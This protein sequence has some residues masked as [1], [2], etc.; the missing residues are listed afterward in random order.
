MQKTQPATA[1][2]ANPG[3]L[4]AKKTASNSGNSELIDDEYHKKKQQ[5]T[6][7]TANS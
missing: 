6:A 7:G 1:E 2:T 4:S 3:S 5:G